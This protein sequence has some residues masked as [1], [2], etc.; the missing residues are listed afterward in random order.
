MRMPHARLAFMLTLA[1]GAALAQD[2]DA[3][4]TPE[5]RQAVEALQQQEAAVEAAREAD[6]RPDGERSREARQRLKP[7]QERVARACLRAGPDRPP[8]AGRRAQPPM[9]AP[10]SGAAPA[11]RLPAPRSA[12]PTPLPRLQMPST[13]MSCD[14]TGCWTSDGIRLQKIGPNQLLGPRGFCNPV[15]GTVTCP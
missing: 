15:G 3:L 14:A 10:P 5:C 6:G 7:L 12:A 13:V 8:P 11:P 4:K 9:A 2:G 1:A